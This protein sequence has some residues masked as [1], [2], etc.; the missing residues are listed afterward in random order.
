MVEVTLTKAKGTFGFGLAGSTGPFQ[1]QRV[2]P[3]GP[4]ALASLEAG[5]SVTHINGTTVK[6]MTLFDAIKMIKSAGDTVVLTVLA[7]E[8]SSAAAAGAADASSDMAL[9][10]ASQLLVD[11]SC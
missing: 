3:S 4:A 7:R 10:N 2:T 6:G 11:A 5:S 9:G 8:P 1:L